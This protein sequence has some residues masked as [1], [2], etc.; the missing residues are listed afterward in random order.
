MRIAPDYTIVPAE[1]C[2]GDAL[3]F[4]AAAAEGSDGLAFFSKTGSAACVKFAFDPV[5]GAEL[6]FE[7]FAAVFFFSVLAALGGLDV[8]EFAAAAPGSFLAATLAAGVCA[9]SGLSAGL[10]GGFFSAGGSVFG[11]AAPAGV[12]G[13][14]AAILSFSTSTNPKSVFTLNMLSSYATIT[15]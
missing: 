13:I 10:T 6:A 3:M 15:P 12:V 5:A 2:T 9:A 11:A 14:I 1:V 8:A 4:F 7:V